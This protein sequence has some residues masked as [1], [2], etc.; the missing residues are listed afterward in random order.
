M[1]GAGDQLTDT[2]ERFM[3][4]TANLSN[5]LRLLDHIK[6]VGDVACV[7]DVLNKLEENTL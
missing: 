3:D 4:S 7:A 2:K 1:L 5:N 6:E